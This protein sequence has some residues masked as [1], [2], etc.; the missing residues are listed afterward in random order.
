[1]EFQPAFPKK[2]SKPITTDLVDSGN[3]HIFRIRVLNLRNFM[4]RFLRYHRDAMCAICR[5]RVHVC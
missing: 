2:E 1:M 4:L 3:N 5:R